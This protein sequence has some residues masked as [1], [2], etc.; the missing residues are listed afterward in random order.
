MFGKWIRYARLSK[1][2]SR[3]AL[4]DLAGV[5]ECS[6]Y[7]WEENRRAVRAEIL[8]RLE[9]ALGLKAGYFARKWRES[10]RK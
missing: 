1:H 3:K 4:A 8:F 9:L 5:G 6:I 10:V 2:L 7:F